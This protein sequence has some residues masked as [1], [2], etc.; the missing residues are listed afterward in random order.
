MRNVELNNLPVNYNDLDWYQR[1]IVREKYIEKQ[2]KKC[3]HCGESLYKNPC[4][5]VRCLK[6]DINLFPKNFFKSFIHLHHNHTTG[7]TI[8]AVHCY[9]N[10]VLWQHHNE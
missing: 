2:N 1:K 9:C 10:A 5:S 3:S 6:I 7:M 8:G 4:S